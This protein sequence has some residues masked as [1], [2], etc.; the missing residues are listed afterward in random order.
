MKTF[1][2]NK[3]VVIILLIIFLY[4]LA[5]SFCLILSADDFYWTSFSS[6]IDLID[7]D[8]QN[9]R[10]LT[11]SITYLMVSSHYLRILL[12]ISIMMLSFIIYSNIINSSRNHIFLSFIISFMGIITLNNDVA[13]GTLRW[14]SGFT[15]YVFSSVL[16]CFYIL[17]SLPL[18][19]GKTI[20]RNPALIIASL[21]LG[22]AGA[23]CIE[24]ISIYNLFIALFFLF[25]SLKR[26]KK[27][28]YFS[29]LYLIGTII[30]IIIMFSHPAYRSIFIDGKDDVGIRSID[31]SLFDIIYKIYRE[32]IPSFAKK[33]Y[34]IHLLI[35]ASILILYRNIFVVPG[36]KPP[37][38]M[39]LCISI[40]LIFAVYSLF[41]A[42]SVNFVS[43]TGAFRTASVEVAL[44]ALYIFSLIYV[45]FFLLDKASFVR[46][47][48][49]L[50]SILFVT[51][52]YLIVNPVSNR[53]FYSVFV[54]WLLFAGDIAVSSFEYIEMKSDIFFYKRIVILSVLTFTF[55]SSY[56]LICNK[57]IEQTRISYLLSQLD[58]G[59]S[60][61]YFLDLPYPSYSPDTLFQHISGSCDEFYYV[62]ICKYYGFDP[63]LS[64]KKII[65]V[66]PVDY[67]HLIE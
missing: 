40:I 66:A 30:G 47:M 41:V 20:K 7:R 36:I 31:T 38:Y 46:S 5:N 12:Y 53:C 25:F 29:L 60:I 56:V 14:I 8:I 22:L 15:N 62:L 49:Y 61:I 9:G 51:A 17:L 45:L 37:K 10:F 13:N 4:T 59:L 18:F 11:N 33:Y 21:F 26:N 16:S 1:A 35:S 55:G 44:T 65:E 63:S 67:F 23:L 3:S 34:F 52:P 58:E 64:D 48:F 24:N 32:I 28:D 6:V 57:Y 43:L 50:F 39:K 54:F 27:I 19:N 2:F 42:V